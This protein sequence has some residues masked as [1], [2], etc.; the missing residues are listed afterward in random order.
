MSELNT[1]IGRLEKIAQDLSQSV[2]WQQLR[3]SART[4]VLDPLQKRAG[5]MATDLR[6]RFSDPATRPAAA[7]E[8]L[9][10]VAGAAI[11][12]AGLRIL[13]RSN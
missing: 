2:D 13:R 12:Y 8:A 11:I 6:T 10:Y 4:Q 5:E 7:R 9:L 3:E 1:A